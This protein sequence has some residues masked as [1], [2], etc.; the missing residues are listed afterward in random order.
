MK[1]YRDS[2]YAVNKRSKGIVYRFTEDRRTVTVTVTLDD[3]LADN[4]A[5]TP[6]D[7]RRLKIYSTAIYH[8]QDILGNRQT[9]KNVSMSGLDHRIACGD[10]SPG[11]ACVMGLDKNAAMSAYARLAESGALSQ[12]QAR[13]FALFIFGGLTQRQIAAVEGVCQKAV[14]DSLKLA[15]RKLLSFY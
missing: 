8:A 15:R 3:C 2:D 7:F 10:R 6:E 9:R 11:E 5:L 4:P 1:N 12:K 14:N 13:R